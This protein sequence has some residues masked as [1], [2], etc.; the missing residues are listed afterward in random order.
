[1]N[2]ALWDLGTRWRW[3]E[4]GSS[5]QSLKNRRSGRSANIPKEEYLVSVTSS[6]TLMEAPSVNGLSQKDSVPGQLGTLQ[7][8]G[9][10]RHNAPAPA[11]C[12]PF[13]A[14]PYSPAVNFGISLDLT[15]DGDGCGFFPIDPQMTWKVAVGIF[16]ISI[17][18]LTVYTP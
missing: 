13:T 1:M 11:L 17:M 6:S 14:D 15:E 5:M 9:T 8:W 4:R 18:I 10:L 2:G 7:V 12:H 16:G 3:N